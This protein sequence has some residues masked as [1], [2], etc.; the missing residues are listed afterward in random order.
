VSRP[1]RDGA[2]IKKSLLEG[3]G[4]GSSFSAARWCLVRRA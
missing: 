3:V 2:Q 1:R 4:P